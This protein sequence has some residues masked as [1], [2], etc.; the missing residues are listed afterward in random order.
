VIVRKCIGPGAVRCSRGPAGAADTVRDFCWP[1]PN[2][3]LGNMSP[4]FV[5]A[6]DG[7]CR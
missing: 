1:C 7:G 6:E 4:V 5:N 3:G 2:L